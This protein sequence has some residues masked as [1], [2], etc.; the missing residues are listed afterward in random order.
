M[1]EFMIHDGCVD[2]V[3]I[4]TRNIWI[5]SSTI[6]MYKWSAQCVT[7]RLVVTWGGKWREGAREGKQILL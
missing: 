2:A 5:I 7:S 6:N 3:S 4:E 1:N